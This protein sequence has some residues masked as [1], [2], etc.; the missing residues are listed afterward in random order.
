MK[1]E[2]RR[3]DP[4][5]RMRCLAPGNGRACVR[6]AGFTI[7][8]LMISVA[9]VGALAAIAL[10]SYRQY[11]DRVDNAQASTDIAKI[12]QRM[13]AF[14][15]DTNSFP[16]SLAEINL[17]NMR[18]PWGNPYQFLGIAG[19]GFRILRRLRKDSRLVPINSDYD[20]YSMGK[21]GRSSVPL[22]AP[23]SLDDIVRANNGRFIGIAEDY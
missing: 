10:P 22:T 16:S 14:Y 5:H 2:H 15:T 9:I 6:S 23:Y 1:H 13:E 18:D 20:L 21:D 12:S 4:E 3:D 11:A 7:I 8:E 19:G 17:D